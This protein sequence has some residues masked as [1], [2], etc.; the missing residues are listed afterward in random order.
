MILSITDG[1]SGIWAILKMDGPGD[2]EACEDMVGLA[3]QLKGNSNRLVGERGQVELWSISSMREPAGTSGGGSA[4]RRFIACAAGK[5]SSQPASSVPGST[6][7]G[8]K[9]YETQGAR[10]FGTGAE[11]PV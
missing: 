9:A 5:S 8:I 10:V 6:T 2:W 7:D 3:G 11:S 4:G 1:K